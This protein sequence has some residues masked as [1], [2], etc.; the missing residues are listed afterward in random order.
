MKQ[1]EL[2]FNISNSSVWGIVLEYLHY[3]TVY[4]RQVQERTNRSLAER[5]PH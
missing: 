3:H 1:L 4:S 5:P 2:L